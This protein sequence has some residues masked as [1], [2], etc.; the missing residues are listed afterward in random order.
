MTGLVQGFG[1]SRCQGY[2]L[3]FIFDL[4]DDS[5]FHYLLLPSIF[6]EPCNLLQLVS[7]Y[8][9]IAV[10]HNDIGIRASSCLSS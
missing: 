9:E 7:W 2:T 8:G 4:F 5:N 3:L 10:A 1:T 6:I